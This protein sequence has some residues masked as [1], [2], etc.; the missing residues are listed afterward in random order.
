MSIHHR[1]IVFIFASVLLATPVATF[2]EDQKPPRLFEETSEMQVTLTG[3]WRRIGK[4]VKKDR[5]YPATLSWSDRHGVQQT[6]N[7]EVAP[8]GISR[9]LRT[10]D[11]P[12]LKIHFNKEQA[13]GTEFR[14]NGSLKLVTYCDINT[15]YQQYYVKEFLAYRIY[16]LVTDMSFRVRP[17]MIDYKDSERN[18]S[19]TRFGFMIEDLDDVARR[20][21]LQKLDIP[22]TSYQSLDPA[23]INKLSLFQFMIGNVDYAAYDGPEQDECCHNTK[24]IGSG[25]DEVPKYSIPY[26][27][28][29]SGLVDAHY[30]AP[31]VA[32]KL[33]NI[34]QRLY[35]GF[36]FAGD[37]MPQTVTLFN[38]KRPEILALFRN[39]PHLDDKSRKKALNYV[40]EFYEIVNDPKQF[41]KQ[42][43]DKC[44]GVAP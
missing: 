17:M 26:D 35:R 44:R 32:L 24:L 5:L 7:V 10:C 22:K 4:N 38:E 39:D 15:R 8:R 11:F 42:I 9:R 31:P 14:G 13:K 25:D 16:N 37:Q 21:D 34:R 23:E 43:T 27:F 36:C 3:P 33:R 19:I 1:L 28:D 2:A 12:P 18:H 30:A 6:I 29:S 40:E 41:K 20:N